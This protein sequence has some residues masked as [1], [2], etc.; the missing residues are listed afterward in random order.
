MGVLRI[1][2]DILAAERPYRFL[3][4]DL[5]YILSCRCIRLNCY[6]R[7]ICSQISDHT[8]R[9]FTG[10]IHAFI[11]LLCDPHRF[12]RREV[13]RLRSFLLKGTRRE[14]KRRLSGPLAFFYLGDLPVDPFQLTENRVDLF[15]RGEVHL[16]ICSVKMRCQWLFCIRDTEVRIDRPIFGRN[17]CLNLLFP[18]SY[19]SECD[20]L[21]AP[22]RKSA[23]HFCP[24]KRG[25]LI[26]DH[27]VQNTPCLLCI[28]KVHIDLSGILQ[29]RLYGVLGNFIKCDSS[30]FFLIQLQRCDKMP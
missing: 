5:A 27:S 18:V 4:V 1:S 3:P 19:D 15:L 29:R 6:T 23:L 30:H 16:F 7:G 26:S 13:E 10:N 21:D 20:R 8:D 25:N 11:E 14:R 9:A 28:H 17:K 12:G 22:S 2:V 24:E